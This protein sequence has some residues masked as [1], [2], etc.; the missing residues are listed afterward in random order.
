M[1][2]SNRICTRSGKFGVSF[3]GGHAMF[4]S[5]EASTW[6]AISSRL[7]SPHLGND[8]YSVLR[9]HFA[10]LT[11]FAVAWSSLSM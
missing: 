9:P 4:T 11:W 5:M 6:L 2:Q 3:V 10:S 7:S 1:L 8:P